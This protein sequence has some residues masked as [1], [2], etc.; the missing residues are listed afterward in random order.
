MDAFSFWSAEGRPFI[1][2]SRVKTAERSRF[3]LAHEIGH[4]I[5]TQMSPEP[6]SRQTDRSSM[7]NIFAA[8]FTSHRVLACQTIKSSVAHSDE[9]QDHLRNVG[10]R[11]GAFDLRRRSAVGLGIPAD[12][13]AL[14]T[15][16]FHQGE[17]G[18]TLPREITSLQHTQ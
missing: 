13:A 3:D 1:F 16:G 11:N 18:S 5:L 17:P 2:L 7:K 12:V 4:L 10:H 8:E 14:T 6:K 15:R 9:S